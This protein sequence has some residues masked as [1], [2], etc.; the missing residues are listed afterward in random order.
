MGGIAVML[1]GHMFQLP[2]VKA[3]GTWFLDLLWA[4]RRDRGDN[5]GATKA[6][7]QTRN[8]AE[9]LRVLRAAKRFDLTHNF[10][11]ERDP[12][13]AAALD[14]LCNIDADASLAP[15]LDSVTLYDAT[16]QQYQFGPFAVLSNVE[17][18]FINQHKLEEYAKFHRLPIL[19]WKWPVPGLDLDSELYEHEPGLWGYFVEGAP[20]QLNVTFNSS[21]GAANG[22][23]ALMHSLQF[24]S[25][26]RRQVLRAL[27]K[28]GSYTG[29]TF[30]DI[31]YNHVGNLVL[32]MSGADW[33]GVPLPDLRHVLPPLPDPVT[34]ADVHD[35]AVIPLRDPGGE[36]R[37]VKFCSVFAAQHNFRS[38]KPAKCTFELA[39]AVTD[40]KLQGMTLER[41][42]IVA[43]TPALPLRHTRSS[44]YVQ[45]SRVRQNKQNRLLLLDSEARGILERVEHREELLVFE[46]AY[47][48]DGLF[49]AERAL[50]A[51][52]EIRSHASS[53][54]T[55]RRLDFS[56]T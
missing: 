17:R 26:P 51:Y 14:T 53:T 54:N 19:R 22:S 8:F 43:G 1:A 27:A 48:P 28:S 36:R 41:L 31:D 34:G 4:A 23:Q 7:E 15:V 24:T 46:Q 30:L 16:D 12:D 5:V 33:H 40:Y 42:V 38:A 18:Q 9:G 20:V 44:A 10:R 21:R 55:R 25:T 2:P 35:L 50:A 13:F 3:A 52:D 56:T 6:R 47:G 11:A 49:C 39:F 29:P 37:E 45:L 32:Q